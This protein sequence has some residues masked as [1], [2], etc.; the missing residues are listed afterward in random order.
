M[1][2]GIIEYYPQ[3]VLLW[4]GIAVGVIIVIILIVKAIRTSP[5]DVVKMEMYCKKCGF[6]TNGLKCPRCESKDPSFGA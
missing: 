5:M 1:I 6:K 2:K 3:L 4:V